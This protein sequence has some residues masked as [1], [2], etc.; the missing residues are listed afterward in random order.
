MLASGGAFGKQSRH[1]DT[2]ALLGQLINMP[3][4]GGVAVPLTASSSGV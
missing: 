4:V 1:G 3:D 2:A